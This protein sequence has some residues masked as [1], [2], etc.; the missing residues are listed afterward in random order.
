MKNKKPKAPRVVRRM[1]E[2]R[3][4]RLWYVWDELGRQ[5]LFWQAEPADGVQDNE[6]SA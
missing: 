6:R 2:G 1:I 5:W 4:W 3:L